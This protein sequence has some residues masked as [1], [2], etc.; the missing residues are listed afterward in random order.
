[1]GINHL[2]AAQRARTIDAH[3]RA[4][5]SPSDPYGEAFRAV[6]ALIQGHEARIA[7]LE[8][9]LLAPVTHNVFVTPIPPGRD[10]VTRDAQSDA[11]DAGDAQRVTRDAAIKRHAHTERQRRYRERK[12]QSPGT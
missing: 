9:A 11:G 4:P 7:K 5:G 2:Q 3:P 12:K 8:A 6:D 10:A 1:M